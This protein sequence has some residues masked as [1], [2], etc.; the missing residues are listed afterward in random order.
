MPQTDS[1]DTPIVRKEKP[2]TITCYECAWKSEPFKDNT[3]AFEGA[4][5]HEDIE[6]EGSKIKWERVH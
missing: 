3:A 2:I 6:H 4:Q 1:P 5:D